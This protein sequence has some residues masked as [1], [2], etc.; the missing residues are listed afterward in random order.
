[1]TVRDLQERMTPEELC[2]WSGYYSYQ[3]ERE[4][5]ARKRAARRR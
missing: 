5:E 4:E 1:M 2:L 3:A